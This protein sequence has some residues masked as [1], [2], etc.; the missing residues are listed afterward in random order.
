MDKDL[1]RIV[2]I[3]LGIIVMLGLWAWSAFKN[4]TPN[5]KVKFHKDNDPLENI[6]DSLLMNSDN[7][8]FDIV[9]LDS[10]MDD[11]KDVFSINVN[12]EKIDDSDLPLEFSSDDALVLD[13]LLEEDPVSESQPYDYD[14]AT[15]LNPENSPQDQEESIQIVV[16]DI[17]QFHILALDYEG[18]NG[19]QLQQV[20]KNLNLTF[21]STK[22]YE[23]L[24]A[25]RSVK[26]SIASMVEPGTFPDKDYE[27][28][29]CPGIVFFLQ[30]KELENPVEVFDELIEIIDLIASELEGV[31]LDHS[32]EPLSKSTILHIRNALKGL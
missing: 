14:K 16:P 20:F 32:R 17:I 8:D 12:Q 25:N 4:R 15:D 2:I 30:A 6:D 19:K 31:K 1:L 5:S 27:S 24:D 18:F 9:S 26:F 29:T 22:I 28:F 7:D 23:S 13:S 21:G 11:D 3:A 10:V